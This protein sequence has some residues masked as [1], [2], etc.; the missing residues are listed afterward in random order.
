MCKRPTEA[1][2]VPANSN[3]HSS[4]TLSAGEKL[5]GTTIF[6]TAGFFAAC[7]TVKIGTCDSRKTLVAV[8]PSSIRPQRLRPL[9]P[10]AIRSTSWLCAA[11][12][13]S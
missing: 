9:F 3:A 12:I 13:I 1:P 8:L 7:R 11:L 6:F 5:L 10:I 4:A 2:N